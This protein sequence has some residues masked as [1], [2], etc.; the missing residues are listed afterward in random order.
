MARIRTIRPEFWSDP[1]IMECTRDA[2]LLF[3]G[4]WNFADDKGNIEAHPRKIKA[5]IYPLEDDIE[6]EA[7]LKELID[8]NFI[9]PYTVDDKKYY[10][11]RTFSKHQRINRP[12]TLPYCPPFIED[13][14]HTHGG[15]TAVG[16]GTSMVDVGEGIGLVD[17]KGKGDV[18]D[19]QG[20]ELCECGCG[21]KKI[22]VMQAQ[23]KEKQK[24][25]S[26]ERV[27]S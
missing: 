14:V 2:R 8:H 10:H 1:D 27:K 5:Q 24:R 23:L 16:E 18:G 13:S 26:K 9:I 11:I 25:V 12:S 17:V 21:A 6:I 15:L 3:I 22:A 7:L 4:I 20:G 19:C